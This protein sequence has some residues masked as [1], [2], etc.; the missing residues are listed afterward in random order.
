LHA[1]SLEDGCFGIDARDRGSFLHKALE[2]VWKN[3]Q[4]L[5][6]LQNITPDEL[7]DLAH[8]AATEVIQDRRENPFHQLTNQ[9]ERER[10]QAVI[11]QW[12][13]FERE[14]KTPFQVEHLEEDRSVNLNGL[15][16]RLRVDY[17]TGDLKPKDLEGSRPSE[18]QLLIYAAAVEENVEGVYIAKA[19][20]RKPESIG[21]AHGEH[22]PAPK[23]SRK[24]PSWAQI[25]D[26]S[27]C[28]L[29]SIAAEFVSGYAAAKPEKGA[30]TYCDLEALCRIGEGTK[31]D[32][33]EDSF[34]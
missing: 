18:P 23:Q 15:Q 27:R 16:L 26:E 4:T 32:D 31:A 20:P 13:R 3:L 21:F 11:V 24:K 33:D 14:R 25:Q 17:K 2:H 29:R 1:E 6:R 28:H 30:C 8:A 7:W 22:F 10:L 34:D 5:E 9:A 19:R 12:L